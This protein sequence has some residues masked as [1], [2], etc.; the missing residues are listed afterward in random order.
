MQSPLFPPSPPFFSKKKIYIS[1]PATSFRVVHSCRNRDCSYHLITLWNGLLLHS[2]FFSPKD[3]T[4]LRIVL[5]FPPSPVT[6]PLPPRLLIDKWRSQKIIQSV[7]IAWVCSVACFRKDCP[8]EV[9]SYIL[10]FFYIF[11]FHVPAS[12]D[13][14]R[15][16]CTF[17]FFFFFCFVWVHLVHPIIPSIQ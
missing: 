13:E 9:S 2:F 5:P 14:R 16:V 15:G 12:A 10:C 1:N 8:I 3:R 7:C 6:L 4:V 17:S 11:Y